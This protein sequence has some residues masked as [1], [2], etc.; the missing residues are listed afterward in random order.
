MAEEKHK[1]VYEIE[2]RGAEEAA[3]ASIQ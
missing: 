2:V 3:E 1:V